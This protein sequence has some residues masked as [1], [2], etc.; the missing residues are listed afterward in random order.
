MAKRIIGEDEG[1]GVASPG[2]GRAGESDDEE[3][4]EE[5]GIVWEVEG[6]RGVA[7]VPEICG[8]LVG[9]RVGKSVC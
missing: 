4:F 2:E 6:S 1:T 8:V 5:A 9:L 3:S 7:A